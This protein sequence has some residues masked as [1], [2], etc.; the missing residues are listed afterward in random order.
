MVTSSCAS[1][2]ITAPLVGLVRSTVNDFGGPTMLALTIGMVT[3]WDPES[4]SAQ[5]KVS[6]VAEKCV[7]TP[8]R[9][10]VQKTWSGSDTTHVTEPRVEIPRSGERRL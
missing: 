5:D 7:D 4:P 3:V 8:G 10:E 2:P 1:G 6:G 9:S